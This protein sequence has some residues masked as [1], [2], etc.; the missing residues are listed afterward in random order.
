[1]L[2]QNYV[3]PVCPSPVGWLEYTLSQ[4]EINFL[5]DCVENKGD[6]HK[7]YLIGHITHSFKLYDK[8]NW[9]FDNVLLPLL[10]R[11]IDEFS[12]LGEEVPINSGYAPYYLDQW[13]VNYQ[14]QGDFNP[15]HT[16]GSVFSF[17]IWLK[18]PTEHAEQNNSPLAKGINHGG[19]PRISCFEFA[20]CD[21]LGKVS[22]Y[23][24]ALNK[25]DPVKMLFFPAKLHHMVYP[26]Y[27]CEEDRV[28]IAG[29]VGLDTRGHRDG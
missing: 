7:A 15:L 22:N 3:N 24:Y 2:D 18:I 21:I 29:N 1:M 20:Y 9:F 13:W 27:N 11:Y 19:T 12:N 23:T 28:T 6:T 25:S 8:N 10:N 17:A 26:F 4:E 16:H 14:R 5:W